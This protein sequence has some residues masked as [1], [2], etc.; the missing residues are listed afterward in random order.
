MKI[1]HPKAIFSCAFTLDTVRGVYLLYLGSNLF[2]KTTDYICWLFIRSN[3]QKY[4]FASKIWYIF[5]LPKLPNDHMKQIHLIW[6]E[7]Q[8]VTIN[9]NNFAISLQI[10]LFG[11][12]FISTYH[13]VNICLAI[14]LKYIVDN[15][16]LSHLKHSRNLCTT[17]SLQDIKIG[18]LKDQS[19]Y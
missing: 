4:I 9:I 1:H 10:Q 15:A 5:V 3:K 13:F 7:I 16:H 11:P 6:K 17:S 8:Y 12:I 14:V 19:N 2:W 18:K